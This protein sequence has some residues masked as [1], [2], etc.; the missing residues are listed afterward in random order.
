MIFLDCC[1]ISSPAIRGCDWCTIRIC[2]PHVNVTI[3]DFHISQFSRNLHL[4]DAIDSDIVITANWFRE[5]AWSHKFVSRLENCI[6]I[7]TTTNYP[8]IV[9]SLI[10]FW[11]NDK[12]TWMTRLCKRHGKLLRLNC[13]KKL[14]WIQVPI[15][16]NKA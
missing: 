4:S 6:E 1:N 11:Y 10:L 15:N 14:L 13:K 16:Y 2:S 9:S 3:M 7:M 8:P 12:H 5:V